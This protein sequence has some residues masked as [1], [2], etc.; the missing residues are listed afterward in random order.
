MNE[1]QTDNESRS[2]KGPQT[3]NKNPAYKEWETQQEYKNDNGSETPLWDASLYIKISFILFLV[4]KIWQW[5]M[6]I[7][8]S[9]NKGYKYF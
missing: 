6:L 2:D 1:S 9:K 4:W 5:I 3:D 8:M 7:K